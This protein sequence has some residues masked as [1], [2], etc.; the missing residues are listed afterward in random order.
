MLIED[1][2]VMLYTTK[3][4]DQLP[5]LRLNVDALSEVQAIRLI[6]QVHLT[7]LAAVR[8]RELVEFDWSVRVT[9]WF[10]YNRLTTVND[11][12]RDRMDLRRIGKISAME[13]RLTLDKLDLPMPV[14]M[15][16]FDKMPVPD[17]KAA[18]IDE[19]D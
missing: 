3:E 8:R 15:R 5:G 1:E 9:N 4:L 19:E 6:R 17:R 14:W 16:V 7:M 12:Y 2:S 10:L 13:I 18:R 11:L